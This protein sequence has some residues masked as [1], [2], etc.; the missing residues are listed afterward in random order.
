MYPD[1]NFVHGKVSRENLIV[2]NSVNFRKKPI[3]NFNPKEMV[4]Y[5]YFLDNF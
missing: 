3:K 2:N 4:I 1:L 5:Y